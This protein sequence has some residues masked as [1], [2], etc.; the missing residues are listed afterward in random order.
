MATTINTTQPISSRGGLVPV[1]RYCNFAGPGYAGRL[2]DAQG[3]LHALDAG[4]VGVGD[5]CYTFDSY[6][7]TWNMPKRPVSFTSANSAEWR[8]AA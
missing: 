7:R 3:A 4:E 1:L 8:S 2:V 5:Y 6:L